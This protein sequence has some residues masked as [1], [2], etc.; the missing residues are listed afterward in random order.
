[1]RLENA[2]AR[3]KIR[4]GYGCIPF[5]FFPYFGLEHI[6]EWVLLI[7]KTVFRLRIT[8]KDEAVQGYN[9]I[10]NR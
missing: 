3:C 8:Q 10:P 2:N 6:W 4:Y 9:K 5:L 1:M 7:G